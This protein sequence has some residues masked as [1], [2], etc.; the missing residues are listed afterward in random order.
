MMSSFIMFTYE[1]VMSVCTL[2]LLL[3]D[4]WSVSIILYSKQN[5]LSKT[6]QFL[7]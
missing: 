1:K 5:N 7:S 2:H 6:D 3:L 4:F